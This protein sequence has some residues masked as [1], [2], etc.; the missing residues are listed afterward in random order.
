VFCPEKTLTQVI[1]H[2]H[3]FP[4]DWK[5]QAHTYKVGTALFLNLTAMMKQINDSNDET[6][7]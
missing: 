6:N 5:D 7:Q 2:I 3:Y 4:V 1:S